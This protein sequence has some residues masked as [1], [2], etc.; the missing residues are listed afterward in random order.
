MALRGWP[1]STPPLSVPFVLN[2]RSPQ[3]VGL[4]GWWPTIGAWGTVPNRVGVPVAGSLVGGV[5][6]APDPSMG[7]GV[8]PLDGVN[9][10]V[11]VPTDPLL[12]P[13]SSQPHSVAIWASSTAR[14]LVNKYLI[15]G[16]LSGW[17]VGTETSGKLS[18]VLRG[19]GATARVFIQSTSTSWLSGAP[20][21]IVATYSGSGVASG[22][23]L[24]GNGVE[25]AVTVSANALSGSTSNTAVMSWGA[26]HASGDI[27]YAGTYYEVRF[28]NRA[29]SAAE[30]WQMYAPQTR[31]D[32]YGVQVARKGPVA[33]GAVGIWGANPNL[34]L[35]G[36]VSI[37]RLAA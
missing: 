33:G 5:G 6:R 22:A 12:T 30:V 20:V 21:H 27:F 17:Q 14:I 13:S 19:A 23:H 11:S 15:G 3:A 1:L 25:Q 26:F 31:W 2:T 24:Y 34:F 8:G 7:I 16:N 9:D 4:V 29:L 36:G 32:L 37:E 28:Y 35:P 10:E 18:Y